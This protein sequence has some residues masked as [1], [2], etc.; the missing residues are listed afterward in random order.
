MSE[1]VIINPNSSASVVTKSVPLVTA[2]STSSMS[3]IA[4]FSREENL[5]FSTGLDEEKEWE[6]IVS[7]PHVRNALRRLAIEALQQDAAGETEEGGFVI[8]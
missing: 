4:F 2:T 3:I 6:A 8:E 1:Y 7:K 5:T